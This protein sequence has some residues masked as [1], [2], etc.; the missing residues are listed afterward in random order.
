[1]CAVKGDEKTGSAAQSRWFCEGY[2]EGRRFAREE[3]DYEELAAIYR[4]GGIPKNWDIFRAEV[5][6]AHLGVRDFDFKAYASGFTKAC[7]EF[8]D[9]I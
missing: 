4:A 2:E 6:S 7:M 1:M 3:A 8:F 5:L 9:R